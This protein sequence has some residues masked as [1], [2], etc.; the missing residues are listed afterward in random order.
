MIIKDELYGMIEFDE[1]ERKIIDS[2]DFQRLRRI[3]QMSFTNLVYPGANHT[4]LCHICRSR[5]SW[6]ENGN[7]SRRRLKSSR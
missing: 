2:P 6:S 1:L 7:C 4:R 5:M 3:K